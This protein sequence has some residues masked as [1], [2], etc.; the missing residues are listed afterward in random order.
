MLTMLNEKNGLARGVTLYYSHLPLDYSNLDNIPPMPVG[1][2]PIFLNQ[3]HGDKVHFIDA[4]PSNLLE[5]DAMFTLQP[6]LALVIRTAD[7]IPILLSTRSG[8]LIAA[9]HAGWRSLQLNII[10]KTIQSIRCYSKEPLIAWLGP[11]L[12][13]Q[14]FEVG[15]EVVTLFTENDLHYRSYFKKAPNHKYH[16]D[17]KAIARHM[18]SRLGVESIENQSECTYCDSARYYS[19]RR[20]KDKGRMA[21]MIVKNSA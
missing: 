15:H 11:C 1:V 3:V 12:C 14:H 17:L 4:L 5:G 10:S 16:G 21:S 19:H 20:G 13:T 7:C 8:G 2:Q 9:I 18:L 6:S